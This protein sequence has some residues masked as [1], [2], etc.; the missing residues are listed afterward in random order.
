MERFGGVNLLQNEGGSPLT[1]V[2]LGKEVFIFK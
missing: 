1:A 2:I